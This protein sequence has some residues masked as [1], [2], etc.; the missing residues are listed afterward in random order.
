[1]RTVLVTGGTG[2]FGQAFVRHMLD[3]TDTLIR[4]F[5][6][7]EQ[8]Q[9]RMKREVRNDRVRY[10]LGDVRDA[11]RIKRAVRGCDLV[12]HA[13][14]LKIIPSGEYNPDEVV[15]TNVNG[16]ENVINAC[17]DEQ[18]PRLVCISSDKAV[19][20]VNLYGATK[21]CME[22]L[23]VLA[24]SYS[25]ET[26]ISVVRYGNVIGSRGSILTIL[27]EQV[28]NGGLRITHS[29]MTRFWMSLPAACAF[30]W[31]AQASM[32]GGE[33]FVPKL[34]SAKVLDLCRT[35][36][37]DAPVEFTGLRNGE[38]M[39]EVLSNGYEVVHDAGWAYTIREGEWVPDGKIIS[40]ETWPTPAAQLL[41]LPEIAREVSL[42][43]A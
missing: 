24:N 13:A 10:L 38:K 1:M 30:V 16:S 40:S 7:D 35:L 42:A 21:M 32:R 4:V 8:K 6:R 11:A 34:P 5:S 39:H 22:R 26:A 31:R 27:K 2:S 19:A 18:V 9:D 28:A 29:D 12:V 20:P 36:Y 37:P 43:A 41:A 25:G 33:I 3:T 23:A 15:R 14:A 17:V